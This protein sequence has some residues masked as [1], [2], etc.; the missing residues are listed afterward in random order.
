[1]QEFI[2]DFR[3]IEPLNRCALPP[4]PALLRASAVRSGFD[5]DLSRTAERSQEFQ[6]L[7][8]SFLC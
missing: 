5:G 2:G 3:G 7:L 1:M 8:P 4:Y 6:A